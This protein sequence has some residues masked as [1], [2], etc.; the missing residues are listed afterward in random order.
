[1]V[2]RKCKR[3]IPADAALCCYCGTAVA[4]P[5]QRRKSRGNGQGS[6]YR[7]PNGK[8]IARKV[9]Y[10]LDSEGK[11]HKR[12]AS[13][14]FA[15]K[16]EAVNGLPALDP[17]KA[18]TQ[19]AERKAA[20][21]FKGLFDI[22]LP[23]HKA[24]KETLDC[25]RAAVKYFAPIYY[26]RVADVDI[27]DLQE[28]IDECPRGKATRKN[29]RTTV[30]LMYKYGIPRGYLPEKLNLADYLSVKGAEGAGGT[31]LPPEYVEA[32]RKASGG[33][34][35]AD[36][37]LCHC[38]LGFRP[39][40]LLALTVAD[41]DASE[42]AFTGGAKTEAGK[43]R[44]VTVSPK[45]QPIVDR[46]LAG[47]TSG[48]IFSAQNG[49]PL[50]IKGYRTMFYDLLDELGLEN[51]TFEVNGQQKHTYTP[52]SCRHTF[53]TLMKRVTGASKDKLELIGHT[54]EEMLRYYQDVSLADLR[55]IT[56]EI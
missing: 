13:R 48:Q 2:C 52:H 44:I 21:T 43:N 1:M 35:A 33:S 34:L 14:C 12:T 25:Y 24:G 26:E 46:L 54:S 32:I 31:G 27:D 19:K 42:R 11:R 49:G 37:V 53:A 55:K 30:G 45:I 38:Y 10:Y 9:S 20:T 51:P 17:H 22:W 39:S 28:C 6:V 36:Y 23:T 5:A 4:A 50:D 41:Y 56:D 16:R 18:V 3:E 47:K 8:Y 7:L 15:T 29:M 40:E